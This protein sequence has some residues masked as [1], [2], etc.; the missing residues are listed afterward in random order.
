MDRGARKPHE[1][2]VGTA[3]LRSAGLRPARGR[4][5]LPTTEKRGE[6]QGEGNSK[7]RD[8]SKERAHLP[9]PLPA[10]AS[11]GEGG[12]DS[13]DGGCIKM[14]PW[15][16]LPPFVFRMHSVH[17]PGR[18]IPC[19][20]C[21]IKLSE[22]FLWFVLCQLALS[23]PVLQEWVMLSKRPRNTDFPICGVH[24]TREPVRIQ[25]KDWKSA[26]RYG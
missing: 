9:N 19:C 20:I 11:Q 3:A 15:K 17:E 1:L 8:N 23:T 4:F 26:L 16:S 10:R 18:T 13:S 6:G 12:A 24:K 22:H 7:E 25:T 21:N 5:P 2:A 14:R